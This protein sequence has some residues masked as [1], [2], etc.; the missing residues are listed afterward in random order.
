MKR[1]VQFANDIRATKR[2]VE[3]RVKSNTTSGPKQ[4][5]NA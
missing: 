4:L 3:K 5:S 1:I 2:S